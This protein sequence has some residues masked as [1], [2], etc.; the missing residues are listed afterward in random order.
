MSRAVQGRRWKRAVIQFLAPVCSQ[1]L[2]LVA[3]TLCTVTLKHYFTSC[4]LGGCIPAARHFSLACASGTATG[5]RTAHQ[6]RGN[7]N[8]LGNWNAP[9]H[10]SD[11]FLWVIEFFQ[12][13]AAL[14]DLT[15]AFDWQTHLHQT[16]GRNIVD[17]SPCHQVGK[18]G[19]R[20]VVAY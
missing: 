18:L 12:P 8:K 19:Y 13:G 14:F 2:G 4:N 5:F 20:R 17:F 3:M 1:A 15:P 9:G 6:L 10:R 11:F 7:D 16:T